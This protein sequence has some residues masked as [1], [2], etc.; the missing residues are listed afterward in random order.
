VT[1][2]RGCPVCSS[3]AGTQVI[4]SRWT[5]SIRGSGM[6]GF[7]R[8]RECLSRRCRHRF[9]TYEIGADALLQLA[10]EARFGDRILGLAHKFE[11]EQEDRA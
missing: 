10:S 7:Y 6:S 9:A 1:K 5:E 4:N 2:N 11:D 8:R 3:K